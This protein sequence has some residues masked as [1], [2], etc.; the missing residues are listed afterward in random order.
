MQTKDS[1]SSGGKPD[2]RARIYMVWPPSFVRQPA[3]LTL[4]Q[5]VVTP[6]EAGVRRFLKPSAIPAFAGMTLV[7]H[8]RLFTKPPLL[9]Y[10]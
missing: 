2:P 10:P 9:L 1:D 3:L 6:A 5:K 8:H 7:E 4:S